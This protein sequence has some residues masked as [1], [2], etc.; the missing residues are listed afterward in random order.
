MKKELCSICD[1][2]TE[3]AGRMDDSLYIDVPNYDEVGPLCEA[4]Y[5][6]IGQA[7]NSAVERLKARAAE[8]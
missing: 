2:E 1:D 6:V 8:R 4:C 3:R 5:N 7:A